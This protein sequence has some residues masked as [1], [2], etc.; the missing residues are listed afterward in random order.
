MLSR[1]PVQLT[2]LAQIPGLLVD[3]KGYDVVAVLIGDDQE[4]S[5]RVDGKTRAVRPRVSGG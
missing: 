5:A 3:A 2:D 4:R 1:K